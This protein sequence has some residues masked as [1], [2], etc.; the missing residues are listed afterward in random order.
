MSDP[1]E[2]RFVGN[3]YLEALQTQLSSYHHPV[4]AHNNLHELLSNL[5]QLAHIWEV[6][7]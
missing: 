5:E 4:F 7:L 1:I 2:I 6:R 3:E